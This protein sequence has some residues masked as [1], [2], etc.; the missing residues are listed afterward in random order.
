MSFSS[1]SGDI[2]R[3]HSPSL[4]PTVIHYRQKISQDY[5]RLQ[6]LHQRTKRNP[7]RR[8]SSY[9]WKIHRSSTGRIYYYNKLTDQSQWEKPSTK[10]FSSS[11]RK[12]SNHDKRKNNAIETKSSSKKSRNDKIKTTE[13]ILSTPIS[14]PSNEKIQIDLVDPIPTPNNSLTNISPS[15]NHHEK[16]L[17]K[18]QI[19][20]DLSSLSN[21]SSLCPSSSTINAILELEHS[22][23]NSNNDN[24]TRYYRGELIEHLLNWP[25]TQIERERIRLSNEQ[26]RFTT[27][28]LT[29]LRAYLYSIRIR[30]EQ[31]R[32]KLLQYR[33]TLS[34]QQDLLNKLQLIDSD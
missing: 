18:T 27:S 7:S 30:F 3:D 33:H 25:S 17:I 4:S 34:S 28:Q 24:I 11:M 14:P 5:H 29:S 8:Q 6:K 16:Q 32:F 1:V 21:Q 19:N 9:I 10:Q 26:I 12:K 15:H 23:I 13:T 22:P 31:N 20:K 2:Y